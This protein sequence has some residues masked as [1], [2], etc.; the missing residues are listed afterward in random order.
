MT[1]GKHIVHAPF[2]TVLCVILF[3]PENNP[4]QF[5]VATITDYHFIV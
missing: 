2:Q 3:N 1:G 5:E 4:T